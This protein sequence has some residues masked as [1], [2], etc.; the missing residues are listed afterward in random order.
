MGTDAKANASALWTPSRAALMSVVSNSILVTSKIVVG[1]ITGS[2]AVL[3]EGL[4][5]GLDLVAA[6]MAFVS[7]SISARP[8]DLDHPYGHGKVENISGAVEALLIVV[9][10]GF[11]VREGI[12][13]ILHGAEKIEV[14]PGLWVMLISVVMN[15][16]VSRILFITA[17]KHESPALEADAHHLSTDVLTSVGVLIGLFVVWTTHIFILDAVVAIIVAA[18]MGF[19]GVNVFK[20]SFVDL[21]DRKLPEDEEKKIR[22]ILERHNDMFVGY[23]EMRTRKAGAVRYIDLHLVVSR[24]YRIK[25]AHDLCDH[26][27]DEI[28]SIFHNANITIHLEPS[29]PDEWHSPRKTT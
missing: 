3:S 29:K 23:H 22:D 16:I 14:G 27:E 20:S 7:V 4:H 25:D 10:A 6:V 21:L 5:S 2:V 17:R 12:L 8:A 24:E 19:I 1:I 26:L 11:I 9:A 18:I 13:K 15:I 28:K